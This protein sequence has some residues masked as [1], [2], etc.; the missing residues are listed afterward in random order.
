MSA[1]L[2]VLS[3]IVTLLP[4]VLRLVEQRK[5]RAYAKRTAIQQRDLDELERGMADVDRLPARDRPVS[6]G[7]PSGL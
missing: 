5:A 2:A 3:A 6:P 4:I 1:F 7:G